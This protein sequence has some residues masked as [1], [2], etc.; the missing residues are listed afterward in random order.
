MTWMAGYH[1]AVNERGLGHDD[2]IL[3]ADSV[4]ENAQTSGLFSD[5]SALERG[6]INNRAVQ[7]QFIRIWTTSENFMLFSELIQLITWPK[8]V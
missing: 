5:R 6:T 3:Y 4:V 2:A 8:S 7:S 1:K